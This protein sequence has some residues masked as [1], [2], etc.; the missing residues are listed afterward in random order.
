MYSTIQTSN[1]MGMQTLD[2][3]LTD[4]VRRNVISPAEARSKAKT[5][6]NFPG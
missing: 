2:Q 5:P 3:N 4:L 1:S 6:E